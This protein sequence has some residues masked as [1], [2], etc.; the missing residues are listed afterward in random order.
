VR[1]TIGLAAL[2]LSALLAGSAAAQAP[3]PPAPSGPAAPKPYQVEGFRSARFGMSEAEVRRAIQIDFNVKDSAIVKSTNPTELTTVLT[4]IA[5][6]VLPDVGK[7]KIVYTLGYTRKSLFQVRLLWGASVSDTSPTAT[8]VLAGA[9][10]LQTYF[11]SQPFPAEG[12][13]V[14]T[15][16]ADGVNLLFQGFD[17]KGRMVQLQYGVTPWPPQQSEKGVDRKP[18][19][20]LPFG[21][22]IYAED[23]KNPDIFRIKQGQF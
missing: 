21:L 15:E 16:L 11:L 23:P 9:K 7:I 4:I 3:A 19:P 6:D 2:A 12:R 10:R 20:R 22:V 5:Q 8:N 18:S 13:A 17:D 1:R 14:D